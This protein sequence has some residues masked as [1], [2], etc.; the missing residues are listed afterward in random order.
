[1]SEFYNIPYP[2][3]APIIAADLDAPL[4]AL[5]AIILSRLRLRVGRTVSHNRQGKYPLKNTN[6]GVL[7]Q[8][9]TTLKRS[10][11]IR[12]PKPIPPAPNKLYLLAPPAG[13]DRIITTLTRSGPN[14]ID[15]G[16]SDR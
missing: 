14:C 4:N 16:V 5:L 1:M 11:A 9:A 12:A 8:F 2:V 7:R 6:D 15:E 13:T 3:S 10:S